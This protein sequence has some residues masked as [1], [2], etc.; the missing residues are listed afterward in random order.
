MIQYL[1][2]QI[3]DEAKAIEMMAQAR[4]VEQEGDLGTRL[5]DSSCLLPAGAML[6]LKA[7]R[8]VR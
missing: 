2:R 1:G 6:V 8:R 4:V 3:G 7:H 5:P